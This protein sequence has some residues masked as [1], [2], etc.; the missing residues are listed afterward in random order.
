MQVEGPLPSRGRPPRTAYESSPF[1]SAF[2][3][4][5]G[6]L[7]R[8]STYRPVDTVKA[9]GEA[10]AHSHGRDQL[11]HKHLSGCSNQEN[12]CDLTETSDLTA[13]GLS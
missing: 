4:I 9:D 13:A 12:H 1:K 2:V 11:L 3:H 8:E 5:D 6:D 10:K 7:L